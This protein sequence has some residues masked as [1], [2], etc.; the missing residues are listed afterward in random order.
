M[1]IIMESLVQSECADDHPFTF[2]EQ[3]GCYHI[4]PQHTLKI[5]MA[6]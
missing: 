6:T 1:A 4:T 5:V 2:S 3:E